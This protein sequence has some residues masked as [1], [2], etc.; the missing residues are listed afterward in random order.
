MLSLAS[1]Y[2][3]YSGWG[4][5]EVK[6]EFEDQYYSSRVYSSHGYSNGGWSFGK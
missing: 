5:E 3:S 4:V 6:I 1:L 2:S